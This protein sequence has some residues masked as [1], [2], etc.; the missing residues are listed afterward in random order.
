MSIIV[1]TATCCFNNW[2]RNFAA[3]LEFLLGEEKIYLC[4]EIKGKCL[5]EVIAI[6]RV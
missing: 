1:H 5:N 3:N 2:K 4:G 6:Y